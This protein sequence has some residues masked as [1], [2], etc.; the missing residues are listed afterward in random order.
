MLQT[1]GLAYNGIRDEGAKA[2]AEAIKVNSMLETLDLRGNSIREDLK[3]QIAATLQENRSRKEANYRN[4]I[5]AFA[6]YQVD[7][8]RLR[9]DKMMLRYV[10]YPIMGVSEKSSG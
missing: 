2:V 10:Y 7:S 3:S 9:F 4:L 6:A 5:C 1:I 8:A